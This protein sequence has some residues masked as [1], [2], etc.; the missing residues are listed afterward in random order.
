M[1]A[2]L[3]PPLRWLLQQLPPEAAHALAIKALARGLVPS[4]AVPPQ[5]VSLWGYTFAHPIGLAAGFDKNAAAI[6]GLAKL[7]F[8]FIE[9]GTT[10]PRP[11]PG[12]PKPRLFR[13]PQQQALI[14]R[15]GFNNE[16][17]A[18]MQRHLDALPL[19]LRQAL[20]I[21][22]NIG[23]NK[24][25]HDAAADYV[26]G[27]NAFASRADYITVN[28][29]SPNTPGLRDLQ[30]L[31]ALK[32]LLDKVV[33]AMQQ[34][35]AAKPLCLKIAPDMAA[36]DAAALA[37]LAQQGG[38]DGLII[39]NTTTVRPDSL[40]DWAQQQAGGLSGAPL[41]QLALRA[42]QAA[43]A[44]APT[45]PMIAV[46]GI[47]SAADVTERLQAGASLVQVYTAFVYNGAATVPRLR[48]Q[49]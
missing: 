45:L 25:S 31:E 16:G 32:P 39:S 12:N 29:S 19:A 46:G 34:Q 30:H 49:V 37:V 42:L 33:T 20:I 5:P 21:G 24:D 26:A 11:Q 17:H 44:A 7:G 8:S 18:A 9:V 22:V 43:H 36:E 27:I 41:K 28:I 40:P 38:V 13:L 10:T 3:E 35:P 14:N 15:L 47:S 2:A 4:V 48:Q 6:P 23:K 1:F